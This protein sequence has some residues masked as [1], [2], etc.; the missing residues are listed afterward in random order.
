MR[1]IAHPSLSCHDTE[2]AGCE[3][4][5]VMWYAA[6]P[7]LTATRAATVQLSVPV[8]AAFG[9]VVLLAE[10][11][12]ARLL[13]ASVATLSGVGLVLAQRARARPRTD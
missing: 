10:D 9:G 7:G 13:I 11:V 4:N 3:H 5:N 2:V 12:T 8:I 6:L 1:P